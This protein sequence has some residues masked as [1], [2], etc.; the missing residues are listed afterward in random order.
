MK[1]ILKK[2]LKNPVKISSYLI[3]KLNS[4]V[5]VSSWHC[6]WLNGTAVMVLKPI[7]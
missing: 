7:V 2:L 4:N 3:L 5:S 6:H 1:F